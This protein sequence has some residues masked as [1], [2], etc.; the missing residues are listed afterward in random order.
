M[1]GVLRGKGETT[2]VVIVDK[3][4]DEREN[5]KARN[6]MV[7]LNPTMVSEVVLIN[8][9]GHRSAPM[10]P[11]KMVKLKLKPGGAMLLELQPHNASFFRSELQLHLNSF[12]RWSHKTASP[13]LN[14]VRTAYHSKYHRLFDALPG[15]SMNTF[16]GAM[17]STASAAELA[18]A[19]F[20]ALIDEATEEPV[21]RAPQRGHAPGHVGARARAQA[22]QRERRRRRGGGGHPRGAWMPPVLWRRAPQRRAERGRGGRG[23]HV[24]LGQ[25]D[26]ARDRDGRRRQGA[27]ARGRPLHDARHVE[28]VEQAWRAGQGVEGRRQLRALRRGGAARA[29]R[30]LLQG[31]GRARHPGVPAQGAA[32]RLHRLALRRLHLHRLA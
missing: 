9:K 16:F 25:H 26:P 18:D 7:K 29:D 3:V 11:I 1:A 23:A 13:D 2:V 28:A 22:E 5:S 14:G 19:G 21:F 32:V 31:Q 24:R 6:V 10:S 27:G 15:S 30:R 8:D 4:M 20:N 17:G 12:R